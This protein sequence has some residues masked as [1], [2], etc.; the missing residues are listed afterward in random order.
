MLYIS[1]HVAI[2][3][4]Q[5]EIHAVRSQ[6]KDD[7]HVNNASSASGVSPFLTLHKSLWGAEDVFLFPLGVR[8]AA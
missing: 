3:D 1:S 8:L 7:Q 2:P 4:H 6:G 5:I